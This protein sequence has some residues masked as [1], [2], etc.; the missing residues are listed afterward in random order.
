MNQRKVLYSSLIITAI[1]ILAACTRLIGLGG[2]PD[3]IHQDE[4]YGAYNSY[5]LLTEGIDSDGYVNPVYFVAWGSGM[6]VLYSY[7][8]IP[9]F[10]LFGASITVYRIPQAIFSILGVLSIY[11]IGKEVVNRKF[12]LLLSFVLAI[13]PW[14]IMT[15][16]FGLESSLAPNMFLIALCFLVLGLKRS[17]RYLLP[18]AVIFAFTLYSY[19]LTW[20][21]IPLFF[22]I[23]IIMFHKIIPR[24]M[25]T[26]LFVLLLFLLAVPLLLF[27]AINLDLIPE[28]RTSFISIPKLTGFRGEE[29]DIFH[30]K[31]S[32]IN[33][34]RTL[35][36]QYDGSSHTS[37][38]LT[39]AYYLFTTP[40]F[41]IGLCI[42]MADFIKNY[43]NGQNELHFVFLAW[44]ISSFIMC[45]LNKN[46]TTVHINMIHIPIIFY[47]VYGL[48]RLVQLTHNRAVIPVCLV[49]WSLSFTTFYTKY[50]TTG[51]THFFGKEIM[52]AIALA[53]E[54]AGEDGTVIFTKS[55]VLPH[56]NLI[57]NEKP[58]ALHYYQNVVYTDDPAW[59]KM[60]SYDHFRYLNGPEEVADEGI[61]IFYYEDNKEL[62]NDKGYHI[63][64]VGAR[65]A[66][67][68]KLPDEQSR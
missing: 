40:F 59:K 44:L 10:A 7:L 27:V 55:T 12:G 64:R 1:I 4:A 19:A 36:T 24:N 39:G 23:S 43:K 11:I 25:H 29:L 14:H 68:S 28:I 33:L 66:V 20:I 52:D 35:L 38:E 56:S 5:S 15:A 42:H 21:V 58:E 45:V 57:W 49:F 47:G 65:Y 17:S 8:A 16:R 61:Y 67:A 34:I 41:L 3:G 18:T 60:I 22:V 13:N 9:L 2:L 37:S 53:K 51:D 6:N 48:Y 50:A 54:L 63:Q 62:F 46:I 30:M 31:D 32:L 26:V